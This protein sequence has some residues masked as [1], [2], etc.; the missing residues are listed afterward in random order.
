L[1]RWLA[2]AQE[3]YSQTFLTEKQSPPARGRTAT[4]IVNPLPPLG[5]ANDVLWKTA[6]SPIPRTY[7]RSV[8][9]FLAAHPP[10]DPQA[11]AFCHNDL[12]AEHILVDVEANTIT[13]V[14]DWTD[15]ANTDPTHD[16]AL[17]YRDLGPEVFEATSRHYA[18][19]CDRD[20]VL[21][22]ARCSVL[23]DIAYGVTTGA[24][25]YVDAGLAHLPWI[26]GPGSDFA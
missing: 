12:G 15:A 6:A 11:S 18:G 19:P 14:I 20:R 3:A 7:R 23:E 2:D 26:F 10:D 5:K 4:S 8:E 21:F 9:D 17:I 13:G 16:L 25:A 24:R 22:Y 1:S